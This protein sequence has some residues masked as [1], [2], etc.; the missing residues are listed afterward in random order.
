MPPPISLILS[1]S[2]YLEQRHKPQRLPLPHPSIPHKGTARLPFVGTR[3]F[4]SPHPSIIHSLPTQPTF[5]A[6]FKS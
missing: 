4:L 5:R 1:L 3:L 6:K 2:L